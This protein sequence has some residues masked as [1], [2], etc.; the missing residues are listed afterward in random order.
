MS[1]PAAAAD[2]LRDARRWIHASRDAGAVAALDSIYQET[3]ERIRQRGPA[4]WA[5][6]RCCNFERAGHLLYVTGFEAAATVTRAERP[7]MLPLAPATP[8]ACP[9]QAGNLCGVHP[10]RP[11]GCRVYFCDRTAQAWQHDLSES[12]QERLRALHDSLDLP[13]R[14]AEWRWL[15]RLVR[16]AAIS[17]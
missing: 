5:S 13:Y 1:D 16:A 11:L 3:A 2:D 12:M 14:Y 8:G 4:C 6:G 17:C 15:L 9:F 10:V 7:S